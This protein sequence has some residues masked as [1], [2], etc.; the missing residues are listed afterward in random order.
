MNGTPRLGRPP[1]RPPTTCAIFDRASR[2]K[3]VLRP[4]LD[5]CSVP[6]PAPR[7]SR[8][9]CAHSSSIIRSPSAPSRRDH[10]ARH[11]P[12]STHRRPWNTA[13]RHLP[14]PRR[15]SRFRESATST[16]CVRADFPRGP[17]HDSRS[18]RSTRRR[19]R[20][21]LIQSIHHHPLPPRTSPS[22]CLANRPRREV[23]RPTASAALWAAA[24]RRRRRGCTSKS[25][26]Y[27][28]QT[29][30]VCRAERVLKEV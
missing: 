19:P 9:I 1:L 13:S 24:S 17:R 11:A 21:S 8:S 5:P 2:R 23:R 26:A 22:P 28:C 27:R 29:R 7:H 12:S 18:C 30:R 16:A 3:S 25:R 4:T 14:R 6:R 20:H 15:R 10:P